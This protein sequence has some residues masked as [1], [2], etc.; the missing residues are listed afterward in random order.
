MV[1]LQKYSGI[2]LELE[3]DSLVLDNGLWKWRAELRRDILDM[4]YVL[5]DRGVCAPAVPYVCYQDLVQR[6]DTESTIYHN[7]FV[8]D[9]RLL[10]SEFNKT[11]GHFQNFPEIYQV[12]YG[13][14]G[15]LIQGD[16]KCQLIIAKAGD[17]MVV[18]GG[19][20][21]S[22]YNFGNCPL[23]LGEL[24]DHELRTRVPADNL[25]LQLRRGARYFFL[26]EKDS[27]VIRSNPH[28]HDDFSQVYFSSFDDLATYR[29]ELH[30]KGIEFYHADKLP[31]KGTGLNRKDNIFAKRT[32]E[33][34]R[35]Y[36]GT[37]PF[38]NVRN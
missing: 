13:L 5:A 15:M 26:K 33:R 34:V 19:F 37:P 18:P 16:K 29:F 27:L 9:K 38:E 32:E 36:L 1:S 31:L 3:E 10:G 28:Y 6:K 20:A 4:R 17:K 24:V 21:H 12:Y 14:C 30:R 25:M 8:F 23:V 7:V 2:P 22:I 35:Q 11:L